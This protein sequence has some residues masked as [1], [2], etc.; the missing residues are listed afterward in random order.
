MPTRGKI[1]V[2][3]INKEHLFEGK[4]GKYLD[5]TLM[6]NRD[7]VSEYGDDGFIIQDIPRE[8]RDNG[9]KGPI[10]G[11]W[12]HPK[13]AA[14]PAPKPAAKPAPSTG[15]GADPDADGDIPFSP[16]LL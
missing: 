15:R 16:N 9:E 5:F 6:E 11:N 12:R 13:K 14:T 10:I 8:A 2:T 7:G 4:K 3:K 1:D